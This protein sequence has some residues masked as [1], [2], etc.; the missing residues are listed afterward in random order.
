MSVL[1]L[2]VSLSG[3]GR[4]SKRAYAAHSL[5]GYATLRRPQAQLTKAADFK[6]QNDKLFNLKIK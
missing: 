2:G 6:F 3:K 5:R 4:L 1:C